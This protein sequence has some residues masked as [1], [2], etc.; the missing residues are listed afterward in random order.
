MGM[1]MGHIDDF[2][3]AAVK[4]LLPSGQLL[5]LIESLALDYM[6]NFG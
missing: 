4:V 5:P 6:S 2:A 1:V 3:R